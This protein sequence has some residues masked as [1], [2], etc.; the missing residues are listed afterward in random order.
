MWSRSTRSGHALVALPIELPLIVFNDS[1]YPH[2]R[3]SLITLS[4]ACLGMGKITATVIGAFAVVAI[5]VCCAGSG[6]DPGHARGPGRR[7]H[8]QPLERRRA[9]PGLTVRLRSCWPG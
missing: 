7:V 9:V 1:F 3:E 2:W 6:W 4:M 5:W 8:N